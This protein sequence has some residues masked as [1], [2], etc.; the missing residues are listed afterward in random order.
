MKHRIVFIIIGLMCFASFA[1]GQGIHLQP[2]EPGEGLTITQGGNSVRFTGFM[3]PM[4]ETKYYAGSGSDSTY[5]RFRMRRMVT[6]LTGEYA[7]YNITYQLQMD[8]TGSSDGGGDASTNNYLMDAWV[9]W[10]MNKHVSIKF[11][12][13]NPFS[14]PRE[15]GMRSNAL[16]LQERSALSLAFSSIRE[17]GLFI[18][19]RYRV[20]NYSFLCPKFAITNGDGANVFVNDRGG[21][22][23]GGRIDF[24]PFGN[25]NN[26]G[27]YRQAD[28]E[29]EMTPK[30]VVGINGSY[31]QGVSDR[32]GRQS[33]TILYQD[34]A[35][36]SILPD[37]A[38]FGADFMFKYRGFS[39]L[40]EYVN[41]RAILPDSSSI[42]SRITNTG[43]TNTTFIIN[44]L[45]DKIA[46]IKSRMILGSAINIQGGYM[47]KNRVSIDG[48]YTVV[49]PSDFSFL[50]NGQF[51][52]RCRFYTLCI[53]KYLGRNYGAKI[54]FSA[55]YSQ[56]L[57]NSLKVSGKP[58]NVGNELTGNVM[59]TIAL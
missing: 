32:R 19:S 29:Y 5:T 57:G 59:L 3:Q 56:A 1:R 41:A 51:N 15:M 2:Y 24:I 18:E 47:F 45:N 48:R 8:M 58:F 20:G 25:F 4:V 52:N 30:L 22:K 17:F 13:D 36:K 38:K 12:Q 40:G 9:E 34:K 27:M 14:D 35:G 54:Q 43:N 31:N 37:Y 23:Y 49:M 6:R 16:Q 7:K 33:G 11:G 28:L 10:Q 44:D 42:Y 46:Y 39:L 55:T 50:R 26:G 53:S 21:L